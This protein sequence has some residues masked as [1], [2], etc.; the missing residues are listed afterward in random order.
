MVDKSR[1]TPGCDTR[2]GILTRQPMEGGG[3]EN[4][5]VPFIII[6][7]IYFLNLLH[8]RNWCCWITALIP[9]SYDNLLFH[10]KGEYNYY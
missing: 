4:E 2:R 8:D 9:P 6:F 10:V 7:Y 5:G 3:A 1:A